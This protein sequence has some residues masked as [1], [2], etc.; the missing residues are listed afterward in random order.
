[1]RGRVLVVD[2]ESDVAETLR[3]YLESRGFDVEVAGGAQLA[4]AR[5]RSEPV[6]EVVV[7]DVGLPDASGADVAIAARAAGAQVI[8]LTGD[9]EPRG[10]FDRVLC[11][12][13]SPR[14]IVAVV[15]ELVELPAQS[16]SSR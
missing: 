2:D 14:V 3:L 9:P 7:T 11:K 8:A 5:L 10:S 1:V 6:P 13:C 4:F 16:T 12:P 15:E